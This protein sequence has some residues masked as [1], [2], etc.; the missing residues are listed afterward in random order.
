[1]ETENEERI[2]IVTA[3]K[4][5][6]KGKPAEVP[7]KAG[8][9]DPEEYLAMMKSLA[10]QVRDLGMEDQPMEQEEQVQPEE[11]TEEAR[12][13]KRIEDLYG[14]DDY[15]DDED[16]IETGPAL[17]TDLELYADPREDENIDQDY[18]VE[19]DEE[20]DYCVHQ[21]ENLIAVGY[22]DTV[23]CDLQYYVYSEEKELYPRDHNNLDSYPLVLEWL[24]FNP[25]SPDSPGNFV[26]VGG[27]SPIISVWNADVINSDDPA[28]KLG[29]KSKKKKVSWPY[30]CCVVPV[31]ESCTPV[32]SASTVPDLDWTD[33]C[34]CRSVLASGSVDNTII[35][36]DLNTRKPSVTLRHFT[37]KANA[38][39][40]ILKIYIEEFNAYASQFDGI[41]QQKNIRRLKLYHAN[42]T[43]LFKNLK[44]TYYQILRSNALET[45][46]TL[47]KE[48]IDIK[49][50]YE[51]FVFQIGEI[52]E[53]EDVSQPVK[54]EQNVISNVK[55]PKF[56]LPI[57]S[58]IQKLQYLHSSLKGDAARIIK[59]FPITENNYNQ[60]WK[61][62]IERYDNKREIIFSQLDKI[63]KIKLYKMSCW[64]F[65]TNLLEIWRL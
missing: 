27:F 24:D 36:W 2:S 57:F 45:S 32:S 35:G 44:E 12:E 18:N 15:D 46:E 34:V 43:E 48:Y 22:V 4:W 1:M 25:S 7:E 37:D 10:D 23:Y 51:N 9:G 63:F 55:L 8:P 40:L 42:M 31:V 52:L 41:C 65:A 53:V 6:K 64:I 26:A 54:L 29:R 62:L 39:I 20:E 33:L 13:L 17:A 47:F 14:L 28:F 21:N 49:N 19:S 30:G 3:I 50:R 11:M 59:G 16:D 60:A 61:T 58:D 56:N 5:I 38:D